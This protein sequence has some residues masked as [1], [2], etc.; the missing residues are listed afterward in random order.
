VTVA[1][2][3]EGVVLARRRYRESAL[4]VSCF[5]FEHGRHPGWVPGGASS[6]QRATFEPGNRVALTWQARLPEHL[7]RLSAEPVEMFPAKLFDDNARLAAMQSAL[8]LIESG[9]AEREAHPTLYAGL[10]A[11]LR[12]LAGGGSWR[13]TYLR[14]ELVFLAETGF[15]LALD[16]CA[17]TGA[18]DGLAF[19]SP[20]TGRA[21]AAGAAPDYED[22][23]LPLPTALMTGAEP[24][25]QAF[26]QG[27]RLT[28]HFI[29]RQLYHMIDRPA[30]A[31]RER[32]A[33]QAIEA[34]QPDEEDARGGVDP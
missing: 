22:R 7:G 31:A 9:L 28:G 12:T 5:T 8:A 29:E 13:G 34:L 18:E 19:V 16:R 30:P 32:L 6:K 17:V 4:W 21:V 20:R 24:D 27:L 1:W 14:F 15:A 23:L 3:D 10:V 25:A 2:E 11:F 26:A 33:R